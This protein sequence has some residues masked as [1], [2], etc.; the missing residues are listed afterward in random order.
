M[1]KKYRSGDFLGPGEKKVL[2]IERT[3]RVGKI[4]YANFDFYKRK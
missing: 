2:L 3:K 1:S 4:Y